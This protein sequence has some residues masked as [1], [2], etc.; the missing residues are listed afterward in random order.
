MVDPK[1]IEEIRRRLEELRQRSDSE[2]AAMLSYLIHMATVEAEDI[3]S[4]RREVDVPIGSG[5]T[6]KH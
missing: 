4:G 2:G 5:L 6:S 1:N 3:L